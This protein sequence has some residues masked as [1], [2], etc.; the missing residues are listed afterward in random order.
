MCVP[1]CVSVDMYMCSH[2]CA[3]VCAYMCVI[4]TYSMMHRKN[5]AET[6]GKF[7]WACVNK[8]EDGGKWKRTSKAT[9]LYSFWVEPCKLNNRMGK[10]SPRL[11]VK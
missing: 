9:L 4:G 11:K 2:L 7:L 3:G 6:S 10:P 5:K 1:V 8:E